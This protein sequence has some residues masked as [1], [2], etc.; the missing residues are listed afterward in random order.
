MTRFAVR[1]LLA[2]FTVLLF[3]VGWH[4]SSEHDWPKKLPRPGFATS[5]PAAAPPQA[6]PP[7]SAKQG[8]WSKA[9][10]ESPTTN[11]QI[12]QD[13]K[14]PVGTSPEGKLSGGTKLP[15]G[16]SQGKT[17]WSKVP[18]RHPVG[19]QQRLPTDPPLHLPRVQ[20]SFASEGSERAKTRQLRLNTVRNAFRHDWSGYKS[21][22]WLKDEVKPLS[23]GYSDNFGGWAATLVDSL[24]TLWIMNL[25]DEFDEAVDAATT[26]DFSQAKIDTINVFETTIRYRGGFLSAY[27]LS[28]RHE[29]LEKAI[30][31]GEMLYVAFD[32]PTRMPIA[33]WEWKKALEGQEQSQTQTLLAELGSLTLEFTRLSQITGNS[34]YFDAVQRVTDMLKD[35][36]DKTKLPGL[37]PLICDASTL[38]CSQHN[39]FSLGAMADSTYEYL[40]KYVYLLTLDL[41]ADFV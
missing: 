30:E 23:G 41:L 28:G 11:D 10:S 9:D 4:S 15:A 13:G 29:L 5:E 18:I 19:D 34:K 39:E 16:Q 12:K 3:I 27:D 31:L 7:A 24:D 37:W 35:Q 21:F 36:Q 20:F 40:P 17:K 22:A 2:I 25:H 8:Q 32:T 38:D 26:I 6:Q 1:L 14:K 33:R